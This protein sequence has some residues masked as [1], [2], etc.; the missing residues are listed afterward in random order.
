MF[1]KILNITDSTIEVELIK[2]G[3]IIPNLMNIHIVFFDN[4]SKLL[5][6]IR[7][8][9]PNSI[10][11]D[12]KGEF[13][14][15]KFIQG[16]IKKPS[17]TSQVR[18]INS[19]E[20]GIIIGND[21]ENN[22]YIGKSPIYPNK[23]IY[24]NIN[25][26]FSNHLAIFGNSGSGK[27][28]S[29][30]RIIQN[31]FLNKNFLTYNAN[32]FFFDAYGEY[33]NAFKSLSEINP[34][35]QYKFLT[36]HPTESTDGKFLIPIYLLS[37]DDLA[38]L[39]Q[40]ENHQQI[41]I[42]ERMY[43]LVRIFSRND[44][45]SKKLKNH[46]LAKAIMN[47]LF[48]NQSSTAKKSDIFTIINSCSTDEFNL[49]AQLQ[50]VGY[51]RIFSECFGIDRNGEFGETVLLNEYLNKFIDDEFERSIDIP[52][53]AFY[54]L[55]DLANA[56]NFTLIGEGF[57]ENQTV[58][59][60]AIILKVRLNSIINSTNKEFFNATEYTDLETYISNLI[61]NNNKRSQIINVNLEGV[62][63]NLAKVMV[64]IMAKM[65]FDFAKSR[66]D[67]ASIPFH[68]FIEEAHRYVVK[69]N[70]VFLLGYNIFERIA[71]EGRKYG[72]LLD[73]VTQRPVE[74]SET[75]ISQMSNFL[76]LKM[77]HP[78][79]LE[80]IEKMLPNISGDVIEKLSS[81]QSGTLVAFGNAF[82]IPLLIKMDMPNPTPY[83][84]N[85]DIINRWRG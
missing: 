16:T 53:Q 73:L 8:V 62:D 15:D 20:L 65:L 58:Q 44:D 84:S 63:D 40:A 4:T 39:L 68:L 81:L 82:K 51:T 36:T 17:L 50:G 76:I 52:E 78:R 38:L 71:K 21:N 32:L 2:N 27:S 61:M 9:L 14:G 64:K 18:I 41:T 43:K 56:L 74:L 60:S 25:D 49:K 3:E 24:C 59:D 80:Y 66:T 10:L 29:V 31:I 69:D 23:N 85:C 1:G 13:V 11:I 6:E 34:N 30:S 57:K 72:V 77:T 37:I 19:E 42:I 22:I 55:T 26:L 33:K 75:V 67:R 45:T 47:V 79:D 28:C 5:G 54:T 70:D 46:L 83:S 7:G 35:Y 48:S 12:L